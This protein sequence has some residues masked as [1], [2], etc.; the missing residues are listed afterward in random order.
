MKYLCLSLL[1]VSVYGSHNPYEE[2]M[3]ESIRERAVTHYM[4]EER[5]KIAHRRMI[6]FTPYVEHGNVPLS[7]LDEYNRVCREKEILLN[8]LS[9]FKEKPHGR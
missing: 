2:F 8:L 3:Q 4:M 9:H 5:L 6:S 7:L 1:F